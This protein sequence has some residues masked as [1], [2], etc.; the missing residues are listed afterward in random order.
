MR[1][2]S[3]RH[4]NPEIPTSG[5]VHMPE[6][7]FLL[8][9]RAEHIRIEPS[10]PFLSSN[11][12][13]TTFQPCVHHISCEEDHVPQQKTQICHMILRHIQGVRMYPNIQL[14]AS[15]PAFL[16]VTA[17]FPSPPKKTKTMHPCKVLSSSSSLPGGNRPYRPQI[18]Q[19]T[20]PCGLTSSHT[21][22]LRTQNGAKCHLQSATIHQ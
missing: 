17:A 4:I 6:T 11:T 19:S 8:R 16:V 10:L 18:R 5:L 1:P 13:S 21:K 14:T 7:T 3:D 12:T 15:N 22:S 9:Y 2:N 20:I